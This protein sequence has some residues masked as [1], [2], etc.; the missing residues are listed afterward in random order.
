[1]LIQP[2]IIGQCSSNF[3]LYTLRRNTVLKGEVVKA[4]IDNVVDLCDIAKSCV[5]FCNY[6]RGAGKTRLSS[7]P[8]GSSL[9]PP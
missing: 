8:L 3:G 4:I 2:L 9:A 6:P 1:M 5:F 7:I